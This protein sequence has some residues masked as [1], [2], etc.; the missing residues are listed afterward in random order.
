VPRF[1]DQAQTLARHHFDG[2]DRGQVTAT[3]LNRASDLGTLSIL[4][5]AKSHPG[6]DGS[7]RDSRICG[8]SPLLP[9]MNPSPLVWSRRS[10][11]NDK[12]TR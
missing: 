2:G 11:F 3:P 1:E 5:N 6:K 12:S 9:A 8:S 7:E 10:V 4:G